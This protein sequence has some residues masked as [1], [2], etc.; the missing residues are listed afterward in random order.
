MN[1]CDARQDPIDLTVLVTC[2]NEQDYIVHT[3]ETVAG[4]LGKVGVTHEIIVIDDA[5]KDASVERIGRFIETRP[6]C[7]IRLVVNNPNRG[8]AANYVDGALSGRGKYYHLVC[9]DD[10]MPEEYLVAAYRLLGK[11][12]MII[13]YQVQGEIQGKSF[14]RRVLSRTFTWLVNCLSGYNMKYYNGMAIQLRY[15]V[16]RW[17]PNSYGFGF[18]A[19]TVTMLLDQGVSYVQVYSRSIDKKGRGSTSVSLR[20]FLSVA[21]TLL[22]IA[23]RRLRRI[24]YGR[25][26]PRPIEVKPA[27]GDAQAD[28]P[29]GPVKEDAVP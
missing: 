14:S 19:D 28:N 21:H 22:E 2:Y 15:N 17:H 8:F 29:A 27:G 9:G 4:A 18:Q 16:L 11:A 20:N 5:S 3:L 13:P 10:S 7:P 6:G 25:Q 24:V 12:E 1:A 23:L 26:A